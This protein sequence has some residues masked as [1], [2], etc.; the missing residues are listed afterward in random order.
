MHKDIHAFNR[1]RIHDPSVRESEDSALDR[2]AIAIGN[3]SIW[4][5]ENIFNNKIIIKHLTHFKVC[6][7]KYIK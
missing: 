2:T 1:I 4:T 6:E 5:N 7:Q 3:I